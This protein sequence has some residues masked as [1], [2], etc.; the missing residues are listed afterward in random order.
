VTGTDALL[1][2]LG[3]MRREGDRLGVRL[4]RS[5]PTGPEDLWTVLTSPDRLA[6]W[7]APVSGEL[8]PGGDAVI[9]FGEG[10]ETPVQVLRC[11]A[12]RLLDVTWDFPGEP[13]SRLQVEVHPDGEGSRLVLDHAQ[14]PTDQGVG[15]GAGWH[16]Y[17]GALQDELAGSPPGD[18]GERFAAVL[19][20]YRAVDV[21][22]QPGG[23]VT[24]TREAP[25]VTVHRVLEASVSEV[26]AAW[27]E[28]QRLQSWLMV[29]PALTLLD[30]EP[31]HRLVWRFTEPEYDDGGTLTLTLEPAGEGRTRLLLVHELAPADGAAEHAPSFGAGWLGFLALLEQ[32]LAGG[33]DA[34]QRGREA[35]LQVWTGFQRSFAVAV[36]R[37]A[38]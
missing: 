29:H 38:D 20:G 17:L 3:L 23:T 35:D 14:L 6:R 5:Y 8:R 13:T 12:P 34:D 1:D 9:D 10:Q 28:P 2:G 31:E 15:Y 18:W 33:P 26:W 16:A 24:G 37:L 21:D 7:L 22:D 25:V 4:E 19:G 36:E 27:T 11:E 32:H 30:S